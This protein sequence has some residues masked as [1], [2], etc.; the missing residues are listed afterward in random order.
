MQLTG[1]QLSDK[2]DREKRGVGLPSHS[3]LLRNREKDS[4][5]HLAS[6]VYPSIPASDTHI[7]LSHTERDSQQRTGLKKRNGETDDWRRG[8][9]PINFTD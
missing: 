1:G 9:C 7:E 4:A 5:P 6:G 2:F 3:T 8:A